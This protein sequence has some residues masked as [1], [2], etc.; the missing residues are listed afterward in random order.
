MSIYKIKYELPESDYPKIVKF[1]RE[2]WKANHTLVLS[3]ELLDFQHLDKEKGVYHFVVAENQ[4]TGE[5]DALDGYIP[6]AQYDK[7]L[8]EYGD[9]WGAIWKVRS[10]IKNEEIGLIGAEVFLG[11]FQLPH[12]QSI[13]GIGLSSNAV[14]AS[15]AFR[16]KFG[17]LSQYYI[18]NEKCRVFFVA[19]NVKDSN[20][21]YKGD[22]ANSGGIVQWINLDS[23]ENLTACYRPFK[24]MSFLRNRY[25]KHPIYKYGFLGLFVENTLKAILVTRSIEVNGGKILR[26]IDVL[27]ELCG[28]IYDSMQSILQNGGYEYVDFMNFGINNEVFFNMGF[29]VLDNDK[30]D[31]VLPVYFEPFERR[32]VKLAIM[33]KSKFPYV[34]FK[35]DADQDR[36]NIL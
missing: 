27:G 3:K 6:V 7:S 10:D 13:G 21:L 5:I 15:R 2:H 14:K 19:D 33:Y 22:G 11:I 8:L 35:G 17:Y 26:I 9:Y 30:D 32:N 23:T 18:I 29:F 24:S 31:L 20:R 34:A 28:N 25:E 16:Y 4:M 36:P 12:F 1:L